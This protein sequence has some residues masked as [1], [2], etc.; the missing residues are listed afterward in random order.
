M[1][2]QLTATGGRR[3]WSD[4]HH[5]YTSPWYAGVHKIMVGFGCTAA[6]YY[7]HDPRCAGQE[8]FHHGIDIDMPAGTPIYSA[9]NGVVVSDANDGPAYG[10]Q[11]VKIRVDG[12]DILLAHMERRYVTVGDVVHVGELVGLAGQSGAP[13]G[14]HLHFEVRPA[15][16]NYTGAVDPIGWLRLTRL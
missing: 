1:G 5:C 13:D 8:G 14:P 16:D 9:V 3:W 11:P 4:D 10:T 12:Y 6:P 7:S 2:P 15:G